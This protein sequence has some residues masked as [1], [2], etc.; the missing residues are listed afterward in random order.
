MRKSRPRYPRPQEVLS[1]K[2]ALERT[3]PVDIPMAMGYRESA[4]L[5]PNWR[6]QGLTGGIEWVVDV[7][8]GGYCY[9]SVGRYNERVKSV[10]AALK[11][12]RAHLAA[13]GVI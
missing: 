7:Y 12:L 8:C 13:R 10:M 11:F 3:I 4:K 2:M 6:F 5:I 9:V 1:Y